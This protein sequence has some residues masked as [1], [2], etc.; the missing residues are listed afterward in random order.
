M[1][2]ID[3]NKSRLSVTGKAEKFKYI[4]MVLVPDRMIL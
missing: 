4:V 1:L 3:H 2:K